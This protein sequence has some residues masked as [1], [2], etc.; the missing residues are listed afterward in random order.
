MVT[1]AKAPAHE[2]R[3]EVFR[4]LIGDPE[5]PEYLLAQEQATAQER[6]AASC[7][8][9]ARLQA[10]NIARVDFWGRGSGR[11]EGSMLVLYSKGG[12]A[13]YLPPGWL[14]TEKRRVDG[15]GFAYYSQGPEQLS[16]KYEPVP[17]VVVVP[18]AR[19]EV[20]S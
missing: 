14:I 19:A 8:V 15:H 13:M 17:P 12:V 4:A 9:K 3:V 2:L 10:V 16:K 20:A 7:V 18:A 1:A 6:F 5:S 11:V